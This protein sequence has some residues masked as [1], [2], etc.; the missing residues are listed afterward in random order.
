MRI[1]AKVFLFL[2]KLKLK[3]KKKTSVR[4]YEQFNFGTYIFEIKNS[5]LTILVTLRSCG[6]LRSCHVS[7]KKFYFF[8]HSVTSQ[9]RI[10][11]RQKRST[12]YAVKSLTVYFSFNFS[13]YMLYLN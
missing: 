2:Y 7:L 4:F 9:M 10:H 3:K 8:I 5:F 11:C 6:Q 13:Q 1:T 12:G